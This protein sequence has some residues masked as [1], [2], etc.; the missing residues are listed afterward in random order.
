MSHIFLS[1]VSNKDDHENNGS[2]RTSTASP[3]SNDTEMGFVP[4]C[5]PGSIGMI[6]DENST[7]VVHD[8]QEKDNRPARVSTLPQQRVLSKV[9]DLY[10]RDGKGYL[11][12]TEEAMRRMDSKN[13]GFLDNNKVYQIM[14]SLQLEQLKSQELITSLQKEHQ[15]AMSLKRGII[16]MSIFAFLLAVSN[17]GTSFAAARLAKDTTISGDNLVTTSSGERVATTPKNIVMTIT[18]IE[19]EQDTASR[20]FL[21]DATAMACSAFS[22]T[23]VQCEAFGVI[24]YRDA[25]KLYQQF[26][27]RYP[28]VDTV[29]ECT[30]MGL[31][32]VLLSCGTRTTR[33]LGGIYFPSAG[34]PGL[35]GQNM[36]FPTPEN[37]QNSLTP[38]A[39]LFQARQVVSAPVASGY[40]LTAAAQQGCEERISFKLY[41]PQNSAARCILIHTYTTGDARCNGQVQ[42]CQHQGNQVP[43]S[44]RLGSH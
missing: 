34:L 43:T 39:T 31:S 10:D 28:N 3:N 38:A 32:E 9:S 1:N 30:N 13:Q 42:L 33:V 44:R 16:Y 29:S 23:S 2:S 19:T 21:Q 22:G 18:P 27:P 35:Q 15:K 26:C 36:I 25:V 14:H 8:L 24:D 7:V 37:P 12:P 6:V 17:I 4:I 40:S 41:C 5:E 20:R 11:D